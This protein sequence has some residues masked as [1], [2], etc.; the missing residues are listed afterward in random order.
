MHTIKQNNII[1]H[2]KYK[3]KWTQFTLLAPT[4]PKSK[5]DVTTD[6][7]GQY[8]DCIN[9]KRPSNLHCNTDCGDK[10]ITRPSYL[11]NDI[12]STNRTCR[13]AT[14]ARNVILVPCHV[15]KFYGLVQEIRNSSALAMEL[16]LSCTDPS[17]HCNSFEIRALAPATIY[18][19]PIFIWDAVTLTP[20]YLD[21]SPSYGR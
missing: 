5:A 16:R 6:C 12:Y 19:C 4:F 8:E 15:V 3:N 1:S 10:N 20:G 17:S 7:R 13:P 9:I 21:S 2:Y 11:H 18:G 14:V